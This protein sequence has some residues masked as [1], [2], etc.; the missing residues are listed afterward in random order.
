[1]RGTK[2]GSAQEISDMQRAVKRL[3]TSDPDLSAPVI[4]ARLGIS[5]ATAYKYLKLAGIV[6]KFDNAGRRISVTEG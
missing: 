1:M 2:G 5:H 6:R 4:A 3:A